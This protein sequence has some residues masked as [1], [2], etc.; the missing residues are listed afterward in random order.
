MITKK[1][2]KSLK[3]KPGNKNDVLFSFYGDVRKLPSKVFVVV[4]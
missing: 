3:T 2:K 1:K 4:R